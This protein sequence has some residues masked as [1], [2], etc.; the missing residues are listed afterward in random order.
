MTLSLVVTRAVCNEIAE[1]I[2]HLRGVITTAGLTAKPPFYMKMQKVA[3]TPGNE[4]AY[5]KPPGQQTKADFKT[6]ASILWLGWV[7]QRPNPWQITRPL[8]GITTLPPREARSAYDWNYR[9]EGSEYIREG[10]LFTPQRAGRKPAGRAGQETLHRNWLRWT[11][12]AIVVEVVEMAGGIEYV[13]TFETGQIGLRLRP[14]S[15]LLNNPFVYIGY[16]PPAPRE[17][18]NLPKMLAREALLPASVVAAEEAG[19]LIS[20]EL[21]SEPEPPVAPAPEPE[22]DENWLAWQSLTRRERQVVTL[23]CGGKSTAEVAERLGIERN[24]VK[25]HLQKAMKKFK[26]HNRGDLRKLVAEIRAGNRD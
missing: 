19:T 6:G 14:L 2:Q 12:E 11:H 7:N 8:A 25:K 20:F 24:T 1:H 21:P 15:E 9:Q 23:I 18:E 10:S 16:V 22:P 4:A 3:S 5:F 13:L 26:V 17:P